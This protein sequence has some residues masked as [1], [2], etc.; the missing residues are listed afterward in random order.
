MRIRRSQAIA[1]DSFY[2]QFQISDPE[3]PGKMMPLEAFTR[4]M[5]KN[6]VKFLTEKGRS[7]TAEKY[8]LSMKS[9]KS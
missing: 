4:K 9:I 5:Q 7:E 6:N 2:H 1:K 3:H 8:M